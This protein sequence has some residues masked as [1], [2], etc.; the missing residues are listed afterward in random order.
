VHGEEDQSAVMIHPKIAIVVVCRYGGAFA[1]WDDAWA[2]GFQLISRDTIARFVMGPIDGA[3][4]SSM[5]AASGF[6]I[7]TCGAD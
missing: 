2:T 1:C 7:S 3:S 6:T 5:G 4:A